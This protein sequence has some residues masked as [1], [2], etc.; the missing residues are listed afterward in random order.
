MKVAN[1]VPLQGRQHRSGGTQGENVGSSQA[2]IRLIEHSLHEGQIARRDV[3]RTVCDTFYH[4]EWVRLDFEE[5]LARTGITAAM[6]DTAEGLPPCPFTRDDLR[7]ADEADEIPIAIPSGLRREHLAKALGIRHWAISEAN[8]TS[9][10]SGEPVWL[11]VSAREG[12][13]SLG[14]SCTEAVAA[15]EKSGYT[16]LSLEEYVV[17]AQRYRYLTGRAPDSVDWTWLPRS[18]YATSLV[19]CGG[20]PAHNDI[21]VNVWPWAEFQ[22][23]IGIRL[24]RRVEGK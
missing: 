21:F 6:G 1:V 17:F 22:G 12:L 23:N 11:L 16:G 24:A 15:A 20:F 14:K 13:S 2:L 7:K 19:P 4:P 5:W 3:L 18:A 8:V 9:I 10:G